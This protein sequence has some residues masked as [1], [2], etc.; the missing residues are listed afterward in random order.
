MAE[1]ATEIGFDHLSFL[2]CKL[3][4]RKV[5]PL[6]VRLDKIIVSAYQ[7]EPKALE[8]RDIVHGKPEGTSPSREGKVHL[9]CIRR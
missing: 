4:E 1:K 8:T 5:M 7:A 9:S 3:S 2:N 6:A